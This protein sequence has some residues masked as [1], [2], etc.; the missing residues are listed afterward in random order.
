MKSM[1]K[2]AVIVPNWNGKNSLGKC[3]GSLISQSIGTEIV[4]VENGSI[5]GSLEFIKEK[6]HK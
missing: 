1:V 2:T 6:Y 4:V 5:D 3:L